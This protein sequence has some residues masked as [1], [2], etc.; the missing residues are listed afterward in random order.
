MDPVKAAEQVVNSETLGVCMDMVEKNTEVQMTNVLTGMLEGVLMQVEPEAWPQMVA[1][2]LGRVAVK[3]LPDGC[4]AVDFMATAGDRI[5]GQAERVE[6]ILADR[7]AQDQRLLALIEDLDDRLHWM[8][9]NR[10]GL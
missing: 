10:M 2:A 5:Q 3:E 7:R 1:E 8:L 4:D 6:G 9:V